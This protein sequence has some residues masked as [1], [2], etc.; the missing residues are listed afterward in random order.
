MPEYYLNYGNNEIRFDTGT[1]AFAYYFS[2]RGPVPEAVLTHAAAGGREIP[3]SSLS[4]TG[5][6]V[7]YAED[8]VKLTA[9]YTDPS[10]LTVGVCLELKAGAEGFSVFTA[11]AGSP[12]AQKPVL[13]MSGKLKWGSDM[14]NST[15]AVCTERTGGGFRTASGPASSTADNALFDRLTDSAVLFSGYGHL[16][17]NYDREEG[18]Y[19]FSLET[20]GDRPFSL[21]ISEHF[22]AE[23]F[24]IRYRPVN[25]KNCFPAPPVGWMT[26]Y[27][28][29]FDAC[30]RIVLENTKFIRE[31]LA[32]FGANCVWVDWEWYHSNLNGTET[33]GSDT[34]RP[35]AVKYPRG[36]KAVSDEIKKNGLIPVLWIGATNEPHK[37]EILEARPE[38][39]LCNEP[40]WCG[41]W[42]VDISHPEVVKD[43]IPRVFGQILG[44]GFE[45]IKWDCLPATLEVADRHHDRFFD[46]AKST[47]EAFRDVLRAARETVGE[48]TYMISCSGENYRS[49]TA[50]MDFFDGA[51]IGGDVFRWEEFL[52]C[53]VDRLRKYLPFNNITLHT[54]PD[55]V[56]LREEF[57][58][59]DQ[60]RSRAC[61]V[62]LLGLPYT[63]GDHLPDLPEDRIELIRRTI[64]VLDAHPAD[65][66]TILQSGPVEILNLA[67]SRPF[68]AWNAAGV[69][70]MSGEEQR[71]HIDLSGDLYLETS[72]GEEYLIYEYWSGKFIGITGSGFD[73]RLS[74]YETKVFSVRRRLSRPQVVSTSRHI[75]QG[76]TELKEVHW[77]EE[78]CALC[79]RSGVV[80]GDPYSVA[81]F[82]PGGYLPDEVRNKRYGCTFESGILRAGWTPAEN[83]EEDWKLYI[84]RRTG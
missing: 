7:K 77:D 59:Y 27:A 33:D 6:E 76:G 8:S 24:H 23:K 74:P 18:D 45:A 25:R 57:N 52:N 5:C 26:W 55:V 68:E 42:W 79:G 84:K 17:L 4:C 61:F 47:E 82:V 51:R 65:I 34:F 54:D 63:V 71:K 35:S 72:R 73:V 37:N 19:R 75:T 15:F 62:S 41:Q 20:A 13:F 78:S 32:D 12:D 67:V 58:T 31:K 66:F 29:K 3:F 38:W 30:E 70:N 1:H 16:S 80:G 14:E 39:V 81:V 10:G 43:Y 48:N 50:G 21:R 69:F 40:R 83:G 36:L 60:A 49:V 2:G 22:Y 53:A 9:G 44:W 64:P 46:P 11:P 28:V 56:V